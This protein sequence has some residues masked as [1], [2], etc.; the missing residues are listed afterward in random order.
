MKPGNRIFAAALALGIALSPVFA[1]AATMDTP[2]GKIS[3][4]DHC[5][6]MPGVQSVSAAATPVAGQQ[7]DVRCTYAGGKKKFIDHPDTTADKA[8]HASSFQF[9]IQIRAGGVIILK[10]NIAIPSEGA[11]YNVSA[12]WIPGPQHAGKAVVLECIID[13]EKKIYYSA[14]QATVNVPGNATPTAMLSSQPP[15][16][17]TALPALVLPRP[18]LAISAA[19]AHI[20]QNCQSPQPALIVHVKKQHRRPAGGRQGPCVR[21]GNGRHEPEQW[22]RGDSGDPGERLSRCGDPGHY[23]RPLL[24]AGRQSPACR[25]HEYCYQRGQG[26]FRKTGSAIPA[27]G[28]FPRWPLWRNDKTARP[29]ARSAE[30]AA[31]TLTGENRATMQ[32]PF[33]MDATLK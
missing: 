11:S 4:E 3:V 14:K 29:A 1:R 13:P 7:V 19:Q 9:P 12:P 24:R 32:K 26:E 10:K 33:F 20:Q 16:A 23:A 5:M 30:G 8:L 2:C 18:K 15:Q 27:D 21:E 17:V 6:T 22:R 25:S 31:D 28:E